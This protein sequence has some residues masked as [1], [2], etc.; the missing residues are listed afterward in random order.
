MD[1]SDVRADLIRRYATA[2]QAELDA[3]AESD[4]YSSLA[5][6][7][8]KRE[9]SRRGIEVRVSRVET[10]A[11][12]E[13][14]RAAADDDDPEAE[15]IDAPPTSEPPRAKGTLMRSRQESRLDTSVASATAR[16]RRLRDLEA[17]VA[18]IEGSL[19]KSQIL[20]QGFWRR[21]VAIWWHATVVGLAIMAVLYV[22]AA[23]FLALAGGKR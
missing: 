9:L 5:R 1:E 20:D 7:L 23:V 2:E 19:P 21:A 22:L 16:G 17:R 11:M 6:G 13:A 10:L 18:A 4:E 8:A 12:R 15:R 3:V 14:A